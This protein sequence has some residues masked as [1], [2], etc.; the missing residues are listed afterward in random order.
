DNSSDPALMRV[1]H[2]AFAEGV[3]DYWRKGDTNKALLEHR[4]WSATD[5]DLARTT[6]D[7]LDP[8]LS[9][10][11]ANQRIDGEFELGAVTYAAYCAHITNDDR[12]LARCGSWL[13]RHTPFPLIAAKLCL[14]G[15]I[16]DNPERL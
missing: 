1:V 5:V 9:L 15:L 8:L 13:V 10:V 7:N 4:P 16:K 2:L 3:I 11:R 14:R 12:L 6:L